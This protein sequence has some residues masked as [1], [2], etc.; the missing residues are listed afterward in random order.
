MD[1]L[2]IVQRRM[3]VQRLSGNEG[4]VAPAEVVASLGA[5]QAQEFAEAKWSLAERMLGEPTDGEIEGAFDRGEIIRTHILRPTWHFVAPED[6]EW[7]LKISAPRVHQA[8]R[9]WYAQVDLDDD[10]LKRGCE[11]IGSAF[12]PGEAKLRRELGT[13]LSEAGI[14]AEGPA[15]G[16]LA[17]YAELEGVICSGPRRG[18]QQTYMLVADRVPP[19]PKRSRAGALT[20]LA[21]RYFRGHGPATIKD[22]SW[23]SGLTTADC[24]EAVELTGSDLNAE[25]HGDGND[26]F[27]GPK[28]SRVPRRTGGRLIPMYD[29]LGVGFQDV[30]MVYATGAPDGMMARPILIDGVTVGSWRRTPAKAA[31]TIE[32][33]LL[34]KLTGAEA[35]ALDEVVARFGRF[36]ELD[37]KLEAEVVSR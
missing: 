31:V 30:R 23:W 2:S 11:V 5:M 1:E 37:A 8:N 9:Y 15:L 24:R 18:K 3:R 14:E 16:Y 29:E 6:L 25:D 12:E 26:W 22:F 10:L 13:V 35:D 20:E 4:F 19:T 7:M 32:A 34:R 36:L 33:T 21:R 27:A 17:H 28:P